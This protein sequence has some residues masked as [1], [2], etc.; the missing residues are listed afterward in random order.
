LGTASAIFR[1]SQKKPQALFL[2]SAFTSLKNIGKDHKLSSFVESIFN[3]YKYISPINCPVLL[4][5]WEKDSL[6]NYK[7]SNYLYQELNKNN[8]NIINFHLN[9]NMD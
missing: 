9:K 2:I 3:S 1:A 8:R 4:F 7:H 6:I 5:H